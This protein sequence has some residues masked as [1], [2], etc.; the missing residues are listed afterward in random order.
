MIATHI[1]RFPLTTVFLITLCL[2]VF[3]GQTSTAEIIILVSGVPS[4]KSKIACAV[5]SAEKGFPLDTSKA[6]VHSQRAVQGE[7]TCRFA[8]LPMGTYAAAVFHDENDNGHVDLN[9][10]GI[11]TEAWGVSNN[12]RP[13]MRAPRFDEAFFKLD[14]GEIVKLEVRIK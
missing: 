3:A 8:G 1:P 14:D 2:T 4:G 7:A 10:F 6:I 5:F 9:V 13:K 11:P 12:I